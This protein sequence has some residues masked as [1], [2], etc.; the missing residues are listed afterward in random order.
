MS[1]LYKPPQHRKSMAATGTFVGIGVS[2]MLFLAIPL[3]QIFTEYKKAP[4]EIDALEMA[5]PPPPPPLDEPPPPPEPEQEEAPPELD[6]PPPPIS[7]DQ[8]DM[9]L[10]PGTGG[11]LSGDFALPSFEV[12]SKDLGGLEIFDIGDLEDKPQPRKQTAPRYPSEARRKRLQGFALAEFI[13]DENGD[14]S[15]VEIKQASDSVFEQPTIEAIRTWKF[16]PGQKDGRAVKTRTRVK[17]PY[18]I[19]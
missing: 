13:I 5:P 17:L 2:A 14:V 9:A 15:A 16:T 7:L 19:Q 6:T 3:T 10:N 8:L 11:S 1:H 18:T 4:E 12:G